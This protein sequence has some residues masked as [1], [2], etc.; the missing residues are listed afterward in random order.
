MIW[1]TFGY[2]YGAIIRQNFKAAYDVIAIT[3]KLLFNL[4]EV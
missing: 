4:Q 1:T 2:L 3:C